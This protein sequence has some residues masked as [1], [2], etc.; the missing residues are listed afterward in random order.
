MSTNTNQS[1]KNEPVVALAEVPKTR[2]QSEETK[3]KLAKRQLERKLTALDKK[4]AEFDT[5]KKEM[6]T[7][8]LASIKTALIKALGLA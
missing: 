3:L 5:L 6:A 1:A 8:E 2:I 4:I 7:T